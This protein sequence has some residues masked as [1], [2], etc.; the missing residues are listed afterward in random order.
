MRNKAI[1]KN[2]L[3][4]GFALQFPESSRFWQVL[5]HIK[6]LFFKNAVGITFW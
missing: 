4:A 2:L 5:P 6:Q 1:D 3:K